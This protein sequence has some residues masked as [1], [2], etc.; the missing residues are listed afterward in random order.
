MS[1]DALSQKIIDGVGG[2]KMLT[3]SFT[4]QHVCVLS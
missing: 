4:V 2:K 3:A 1:Y